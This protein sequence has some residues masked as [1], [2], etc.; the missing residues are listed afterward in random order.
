[1]PENKAK[2]PRS[3]GPRFQNQRFRDL[4]GEL[5]SY[6]LCSGIIYQYYYESAAN[7]QQWKADD[8]VK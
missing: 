2:V 8:L 5:R 3:I 1:M 7:H 4:G 6:E